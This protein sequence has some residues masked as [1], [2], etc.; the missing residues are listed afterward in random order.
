MFTEAA[1][2]ML[3]AKAKELW[4][5][6][7]KERTINCSLCASKSKPTQQHNLPSA[8]G[9]FPWVCPNLRFGGKS[10]STAC[11]VAQDPEP[12]VGVR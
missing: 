7:K 12:I 8:L 1:L 3:A 10:T 5:E 4:E 9:H 6:K 2:A 11:L